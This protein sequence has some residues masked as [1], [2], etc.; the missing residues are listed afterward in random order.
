MET[1]FTPWTGLLGGLMIGGAAL[2]L[3]WINGRVAGISGILGGALT[4]S[5]SERNWRLVFL[6]GLLLGGAIGIYG[7]ID[8][9]SIALVAE[10][11]MLIPAGLLVGY[12]TRLGGG[13]TSGHGVCGIGRLSVRSVTGT[14]VFML[15]AALTVYVQRHLLGQQS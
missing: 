1:T 9:S 14:I 8:R 10:W 6:A 11:P 2:L 12:G 13:C 3:L 15:T 5:G 7:L 4:S